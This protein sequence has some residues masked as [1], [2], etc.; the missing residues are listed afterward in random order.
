MKMQSSVAAGLCLSLCALPAAA[1]ESISRLSPP[2]NVV[3][4]SVTSDA[5]TAAGGASALEHESMVIEEDGTVRFLTPQ[6]AASL[7]VLPGTESLFSVKLDQPATG[8]DSL[9]IDVT[10]AKITESVTPD[11]TTRMLRILPDD[12]SPAQMITITKD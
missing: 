3:Q 6:E 4:A 11:G 5:G 9:H 7:F 2:L 12:G 8:S 10:G 1:Q